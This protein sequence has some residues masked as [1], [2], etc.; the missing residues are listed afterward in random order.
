MCRLLRLNWKLGK[1]KHY[2]VVEWW[3]YKIGLETALWG[4]STC[5]GIIVHYYVQDQHQHYTLIIRASYLHY[6][7]GI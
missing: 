4:I 1:V 3:L 7:E 5:C 6:V 2:R